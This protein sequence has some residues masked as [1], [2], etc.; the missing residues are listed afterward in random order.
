[1]ISPGIFFIFG[2]LGGGGG[3]GGKKKKKKKNLSVVVDILGTIYY[4]IVIYGTLV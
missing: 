4:V 3:G 1:M 2:L